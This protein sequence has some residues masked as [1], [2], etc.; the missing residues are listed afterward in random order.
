[1]VKTFPILLLALP[2]AA[3]CAGRE[4]EPPTP[5][6]VDQYRIQIPGCALFLRS[7]GPA[8]GPPILLLHGAAFSSETWEQLGTIQALAAAGMR[9]LAVDLPGHGQSAAGGP[10][11]EEWVAAILDALKVEKAALLA[12]SMSGPAALSFVAAHPERVTRFV[13]VAPVG[14]EEKLSSLQGSPVRTLVIWS[15][16]DKVV[17]LAHGEQLVAAMPQARLE[18]MK[19]APH[20]CYLG[21]TAAFHR[22]LL[23]FLTAP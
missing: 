4:A 15:D 19:G 10:P 9:V 17:P 3:A 18:V 20:P 12:A 2:M 6:T 22:H 14:V 7:A 11:P 1:M 23:D 13:A 5:P 21:D 16:V 8:D